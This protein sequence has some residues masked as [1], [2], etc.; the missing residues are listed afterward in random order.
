MI[1]T[2]VGALLALSAPATNDATPDQPLAPVVVTATRQAEDPMTVPAAVDVLDAERIG[3]ARPRVNL[4]E[5]LQ[6]L[7]GVVARDRQNQ[8]QD[9]QISIR[10]FG[11]RASFG[12][13]GVRI[14]SDGIPATMPD[15]QGQVSHLVLPVAGRIEVLRGP[16]SALYGNAAGG[17]IDVTSAVAP[18]EPEAVGGM[19][20]GDFGLRHASAGW[21][22]RWG[23]PGRAMPWS[24][25]ARSAATASAGTAATSASRARRWSAV[26]WA[27]AANGACWPTTC[28][29]RRSIRRA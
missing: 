8:A 3:R 15:G 9:L 23:R 1:W 25:S 6:Q 16:F 28:G 26:A 20:L 19:V 27:T 2:T 22:S 17:V 14:Y 21:R 24:T 7:P 4:S 11:A 13:R 12:V 5:V 10:G 18:A 29:C